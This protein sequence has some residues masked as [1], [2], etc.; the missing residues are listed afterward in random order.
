[1]IHAFK[2]GCTVQRLEGRTI[3]RGGESIK[4]PDRILIN[5]EGKQYNLSL[6]EAQAFTIAVGQ[7]LGEYVPYPD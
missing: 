1:M 2:S 4:Q 7:S 5:M 3:E 6:E